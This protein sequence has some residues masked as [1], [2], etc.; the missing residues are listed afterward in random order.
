[1]NTLLDEANTSRVIVPDH[2][3]S[4]KLSCLASH[5]ISVLQQE[6]LAHAVENIYISMEINDIVENN[7]Y[8]SPSSGLVQCTR[9]F[10][11]L[12]CL[13]N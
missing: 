3:N 7:G 2:I 5:L 12:L 11:E 1:M 9:L 13:A 6:D 10:Q 4:A 8:S